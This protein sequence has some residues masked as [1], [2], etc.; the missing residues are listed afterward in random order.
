MKRILLSLLTV[1]TFLA[2]E[3]SK[4]S[5]T[6]T[7]PKSSGTLNNVSVVIANDL[8]KG[9]VGDAVRNVLA[10][11][12]DGL[13]QDEPLFSMNQI[14]PEVF[15]GF[16]AK[17]RTVLK[18]EKGGE[19]AIKVATNPYAKPQKMIVIS[20]P[21]NT[22]IIN[23]IKTNAAKIVKVFKDEELT[24]KQRR[25]KLSL[26]KTD[27]ITRQLGISI[28][29]P[30]AYRIAKQDNN[31]F[32]IRKDIT[33]GTSNLMLFTIPKTDIDLSKNLAPQ[34]IKIRDSIGKKYIEGGA[35]GTYMGTE[36][37]YAPYVNKIILD[38][39]P[40]IETKGIWDLKNGFMSGPFVNYIIEDAINNRYVVA[41]GFTFAPSVSKREY[42]FELESII[43]SIK[44]E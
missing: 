35:E 7:L 23:E 14:P 13:P 26:F 17:N 37:K 44:I 38:N 4:S 3:D 18:V 5:G 43:K 15:S 32:W 19:A 40:T 22:A 10:A 36:D 2:C 27:S 8:W 34:V 6:R 24:E 25:I 28:A 21:D 33:T 31:F 16:A 30:T 20:G 12:V 11:P 42:V 39:K 41:E 1:I 9:R 29:F